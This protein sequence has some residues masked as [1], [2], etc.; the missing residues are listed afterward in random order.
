MTFSSVHCSNFLKI[1]IDSAK[2]VGL[3]RFE[4]EKKMFRKRERKRENYAIN[5][6]FAFYFLKVKIKIIFESLKYM[7]LFGGGVWFLIDY[8]L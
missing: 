4:K 8:C 1:K 3:E 5:L 6:L 2:L 7:T